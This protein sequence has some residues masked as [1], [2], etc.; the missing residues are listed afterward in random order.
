MMGEV[1]DPVRLHRVRVVFQPKLEGAGGVSHHTVYM[2][3][4]WSHVFG[5]EH[6]VD[7]FSL[8]EITTWGQSKI[9]ELA[10]YG[11]V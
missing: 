2:G 5:L 10:S 4:Y 6:L 3:D 11:W 9:L 8:K 1:E 7:D